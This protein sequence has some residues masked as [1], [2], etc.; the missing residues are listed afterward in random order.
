MTREQERERE[1]ER[2]REGESAMSLVQ[3]KSGGEG[4]RVRIRENNRENM[5]CEASELGFWRETESSLRRTRK[6]K[7]KLRADAR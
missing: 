3:I 2:E 4:G 6:P 5:Q 7:P 1:R